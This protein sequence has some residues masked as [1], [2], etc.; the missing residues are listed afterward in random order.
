MVNVKIV[1]GFMKKKIYSIPQVEVEQI[2]MSSAL[3]VGSPD[4]T[5]FT[6]GDPVQPG[7]PRRRDMVF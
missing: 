3:L 4:N 5:D 2:N 7:A 1:N 6:P